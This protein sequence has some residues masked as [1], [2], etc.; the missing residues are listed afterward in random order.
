[1]VF[2][3]VNLIG[4]GKGL[5]VQGVDSCGDHGIGIRFGGL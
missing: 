5:A 2:N 3:E 1:M 4:G